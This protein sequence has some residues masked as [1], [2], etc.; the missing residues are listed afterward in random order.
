MDRK[1]KLLALGTLLA[2]V[3]CLALPLAAAEKEPAVGLQMGNVQFPGPMS[4][5]DQKYLGLDKSGPFTLKNIKSPYVLVESFS[6][7]CPH[8]MAQAPVLNSLYTMVQQDPKLKGKLKFLSMAQGNDEGPVK[9]WKVFHKVPFPIIPDPKHTFGK[10]MNFQP[11]PVTVV[12]DK[13]GKVVWTH[14]GAFESA[15][16]ALKGIKAVVK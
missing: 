9:M 10:A 13:S 16:E 2:L 7:T 15:D 11:F 4:G 6:T 8:C 14:V 12:L 3:L 1:G 5:D